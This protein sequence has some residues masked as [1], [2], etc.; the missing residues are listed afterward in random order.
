[1][2]TSTDSDETFSKYRNE[3]VCKICYKHGNS[4]VNNDLEATTGIYFNF[5]IF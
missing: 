3:L 2:Y 4:T 5:L 1:M